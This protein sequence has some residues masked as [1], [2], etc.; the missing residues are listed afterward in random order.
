[1]IGTI[2]PRSA[3]CHENR[4]VLRKTGVVTLEPGIIYG[5]LQ[6]TLH[7]HNRFLPPFPSSIEFCSIGG[8]IANNAGGEKTVKYG[9][10]RDYT[11]ALRVVLANGE[12]ME[13]RRLSKRELNKKLGLQTFELPAPRPEDRQI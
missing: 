11:R 12:V 9:S 2:L 4:A 1:M 3:N 13:T 8:A 7:T 10:T 6:Q 5:K